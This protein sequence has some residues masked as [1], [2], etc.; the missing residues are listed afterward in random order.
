MNRIFVDKAR[1]FIHH[2]LTFETEDTQ[3]QFYK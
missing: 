3:L 1:I 2:A